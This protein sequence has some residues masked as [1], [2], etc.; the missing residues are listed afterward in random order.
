MLVFYKIRSNRVA[1]DIRKQALSQLQGLILKMDSKSKR[2]VFATKKKVIGIIGGSGPEAGADLF[3]KV[4]ALHRT[5]LGHSYRSDRDAPNIVL[6]SVADLGGPRTSIDLEPGNSEGT[7]DASLT[8]LIET[9]R[10]MLPLVDV[11]SLAC[12]TLHTMEPQLLESISN[13]GRDPSVF[14]SMVGATIRACKSR[15]ETAR[16]KRQKTKISILGG[17]ATLDLSKN[18]RSSYKRLLEELGED[19]FYVLPHSA[20]CILQTIIWQIKDLGRPPTSGA[21]L[22]AYKDLV[23]ELATEHGVSICVLACTELPLIDIRSGN[24]ENCLPDENTVL[25]FI[26]PTEV[27]A[28]ALL[29][30]THNYPDSISTTASPNDWM[31]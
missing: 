25:E 4:L 23:K 6:M 26:D 24:A 7:Y 22:E 28:S 29:D 9:V 15:L 3:G 27:V 1:R 10:T 14:C 5:K 11:F 31:A 2:P 8:A 16:S 17:P 19:A 21:A 12:N 30:A 18:S 13:A 20:I